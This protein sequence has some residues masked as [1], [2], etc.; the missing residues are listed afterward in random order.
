MRQNE[1]NLITKVFFDTRHAQFF[2]IDNFVT[3]FLHKSSCKSRCQRHIYLFCIRSALIK[4][5][6]Y[7]LINSTVVTIYAYDPVSTFS[8]A[9][10]PK[11]FIDRDDLLAKLRTDIYGEEGIQPHSYTSL[12]SR[13]LEHINNGDDGDDDELMMMLM[14][15][16]LKLIIMI[17]SLLLLLLLFC[18][19]CCFCY[20]EW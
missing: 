9:S 1:L 19:C 2:N 14:I 5:L 7:V 11:H 20:W 13:E 3:H 10:T 8:S 4:T 6:L 17:I 18:F 15:I 12:L 16:K